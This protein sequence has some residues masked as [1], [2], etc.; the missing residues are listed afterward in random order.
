MARDMASECMYVQG[1]NII[2]TY[3]KE[4][5]LNFIYSKEHT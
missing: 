2:S 1:I 3:V 4:K 5:I